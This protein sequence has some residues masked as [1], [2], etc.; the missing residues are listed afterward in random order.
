MDE[1]NYNN[2]ICWLGLWLQ[3]Q[4]WWVVGR[5]GGGRLFKASDGEGGGGGGDRD[6]GGGPGAQWGWRAVRAPA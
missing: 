3:T 1:Y 2:I 6:G 5:G 4:T